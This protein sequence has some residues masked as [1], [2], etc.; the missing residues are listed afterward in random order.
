MKLAKSPK[1]R[2]RFIWAK[3]MRKT[4]QQLLRIYAVKWERGDYSNLVISHSETANEVTY[5]FNWK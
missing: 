5:T 1:L 4:A 2:Y 3:V